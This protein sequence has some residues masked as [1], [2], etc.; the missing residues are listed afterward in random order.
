MTAED[1]WATVRYLKQLPPKAGYSVELAEQ[2]DN[3]STKLLSGDYS[4]KGALEYVEH[5]A[6]VKYNM[7]MG[8]T[9]N[10]PQGQGHV[11]SDQDA[12]DV[13]YYFTQKPHPDFP[14][15]VN[16]WPSGKKPKDSRY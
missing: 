7:P 14:A 12:V 9:M 10:R 8:Y 11:L 13:S 6:V 16:D 1:R 5:C 15:K 4:E 3:T 2:Q